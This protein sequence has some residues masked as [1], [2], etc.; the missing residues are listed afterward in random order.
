MAVGAALA[1]LLACEPSAVG[2]PAEAAPAFEAL[3]LDGSPVRLDDFRG[4]FV[5]IDF[6]ATWCP[7]CVLEIPELNAVWERVKGRGV[8]V[9]ALSVDDLPR[10]QIARW[11]RERGAS[12]PIALADI[13]L[14]LAYG[15]A[16]FPF[17]VVV[18]PG[19]ELLERLE[20]GYHDR[21]ELIEVLNRHAEF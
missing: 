2:E 4:Q 6:W 3:R 10:D 17:H 7:P 18:G 14:A 21:H 16:Q 19:G 5:L 12:Y 9:L 11:A 20:P 8:E 15:A 1:L 13:D